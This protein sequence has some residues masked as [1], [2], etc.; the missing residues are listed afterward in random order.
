MLVATL[1]VIIVVFALYL[2][3]RALPYAILLC[4]SALA[5]L[6]FT[7]NRNISHSQD[8]KFYQEEQQRLRLLSE[9]TEGV[10]AYIEKETEIIQALPTKEFA[11]HAIINLSSAYL[12][13]AQPQ[14]ALEMLDRLDDGILNMSLKAMCA[15]QRLDAALQ[16]KQPEQAGK[17][18]EDACRFAS[19]LRGARITGMLRIMSL[20]YDVFSGE[21][22]KALEE[23]EALP[24]DFTDASGEQLLKILQATC[25]ERLGRT[26]DAQNTLRELRGVALL[27]FLAALAAEIPGATELLS[28]TSASKTDTNI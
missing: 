15:L 6:F 13:N 2:K 27:P 26:E 3:Y 28:L 21:Y 1:A 23:I 24:E 12:M 7:L 9:G 11:T 5:C 4:A 22:A 18:Y 8:S 10:A 20:R 16:M 17:F 14:K 19:G 25:L